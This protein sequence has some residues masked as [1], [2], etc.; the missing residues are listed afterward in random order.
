MTTMIVVIVVILLLLGLALLKKKPDTN[1]KFH[2]R[3]PLSEPEQQLFWK[4]RSALPDHVVLPQV[5]FSRF[6]YAKGATNNEN[7]RKLARA[8]QKVA[9]FLVCDKTFFIIAVVELDDSSHNPTKDATRDAILKEAGLRVVRWK[10][11]TMPTEN[12]IRSI[13][14][15]KN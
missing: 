7:F 4:L 11:N 14:T 5:S 6:L 10:V 15:A 9:D 3:R 2:P 13:L 8:K 12:E 1:S